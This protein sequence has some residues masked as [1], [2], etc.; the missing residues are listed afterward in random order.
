MRWP[1]SFLR[2][3]TGST[4]PIVALIILGALGMFRLDWTVSVWQVVTVLWVS[5]VF[6]F[7][8]LRKLDKIIAI[9]EEFPPHRHVH[10][11]P[12]PIYPRGMKPNGD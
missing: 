2:G 3:A 7:A 4:L 8:V 9:F 11:S 1:N 10:G 12:E 6:F 5:F